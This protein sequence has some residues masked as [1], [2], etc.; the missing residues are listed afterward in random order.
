M[1]SNDT[2][3]EAEEVVETD[4]MIIKHEDIWRA[5]IY[6]KIWEILAIINSK[7]AT[8]F[9][10]KDI[11]TVLK[12][13]AS[14]LQLVNLE[15]RILPKRRESSTKKEIDIDEQCLARCWDANDINGKRCSRRKDSSSNLCKAHLKNAPHG[16]ITEPINPYL[17]AN[18]KKYGAKP[19]D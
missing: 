9:K 11:N 13:V 2:E 19:K 14:R 7:Y 1:A 4:T 3:L 8:A 6:K 15:R 18:F 17:I 10:Y 16:L 5:I 12:N